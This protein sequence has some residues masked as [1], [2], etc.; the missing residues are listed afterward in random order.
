VH[1]LKDL[2]TTLP[3]GLHL[4]AICEREDPRDSVIFRA[5]TAATSLADLPAGA[6]VGTSSLRRVAQLTAR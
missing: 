3:D 6:W 2:P 1:S 5:G 4:G